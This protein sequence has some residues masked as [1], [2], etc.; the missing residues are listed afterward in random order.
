MSATIRDTRRALRIV[1]GNLRESEREYRTFQKDRRK[2]RS[3]FF[4]FLNLLG[5][6]RGRETPG[7][8]N[9]IQI[10]A[11]ETNRLESEPAAN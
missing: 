10:S 2:T 6:T 9:F 4:S 7:F 5:F 1:E 3:F 11:R 8:D